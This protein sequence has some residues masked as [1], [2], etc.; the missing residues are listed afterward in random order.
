MLTSE[1]S[2]YGTILATGSGHTLYDFAIDTPTKSRCPNGACTIQWPPLL[3]R[4]RVVTEGG[5]KASLVGHITRP[6]G[7]HQV[8]YAG[9]PLYTYLEDTE[10]HQ[11]TGQAL[12]Q[13]GAS[14]YVITV[15]GQ[16]VT[17][18]TPGG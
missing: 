5:V 17:E 4:G 11:T 14:W 10:P 15:S 3:V 2:A 13:Y 1:R 12:L 8:T 16:Q 18:R 6:G 7:A 9:H